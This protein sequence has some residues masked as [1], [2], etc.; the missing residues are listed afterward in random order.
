MRLAMARAS[1]HM[2]ALLEWV[3]ASK[4][5]CAAPAA[6]RA[7]QIFAGLALAVGQY[8]G[9]CAILLIVFLIPATLVAHSFWLAPES[10]LSDSSNRFASTLLA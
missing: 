5:S 3:H 2:S 9:I 1:S 7:V 8:R 10:A 4:S 6:G